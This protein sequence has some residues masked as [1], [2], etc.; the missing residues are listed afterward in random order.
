MLSKLWHF[1]NKDIL[2]SVYYTIFHSHLAYLCLVWGRAKYFL[3][4]IALLQ[5]RVITILQSDTYRDLTCPL[6]S[7]YKV[8]DLV[9]LEK[10]LFVSKCFNDDA[11]S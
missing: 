7:K 11:F 10:C 9:S 2:L 8:I 1:V 5:K 6:F 4:R 3:N